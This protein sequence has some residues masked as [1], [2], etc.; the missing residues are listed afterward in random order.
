MTT[1]QDSS[2]YIAPAPDRHAL[3]RA[4]GLHSLE[5]EFSVFGLMERAGAATAERVLRLRRDNSLPVLLVAGPGNNGGDALVTARR[6][7]RQGVALC[8]VLAADPERQPADAAAALAALR[9]AGV[10]VATEIPAGRFSLVVD[11]LFGIGLSRPLTGRYA[12]GVRALQNAAAA[13]P[14]L[15]LDCPSGLDADT[16]FAAG[17]SV[18]ATHT[19]SFIAAKPGLYTGAGPD[20]AGSIEVD[21]LGIAERD[22]VRQ[23]SGWLLDDDDDLRAA[24]RPRAKNSHKGDFGSLGVLGGA[25]GMTGAALLCGRAA[26]KLGCG[27]V[28]AGLPERSLAVDPQQAELMLRDPAALAGAPLTA[29]VCGPGLGTGVRADALLTDIVGSPLPLVLDADA[30][31]LIATGGLAAQR[32]RTRHGTSV[33]TPHPGE[34]ARLLGCTT[35]DIARDRVGAACRIAAEYNA[36]VAL[37]GCGTVIADADGQWWINASGNPLLA[38]AGTGDVLAGFVGALLAQGNNAGVA[39]RAAVSLHG[40]AADAALADGIAIG[41]AAGELID[42][43]RRIA[44]RIIGQAS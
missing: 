11:G 42:A 36:W 7:H 1:P 3:L 31:T 18:R 41:L 20:H 33:L 26:L 39:L 34:A 4:P 9:D 8:I 27:R 24:F 22:I 17:P 6:L 16:G 29:L 32:L 15:A 35:R 40:Q 23:A 5:K 38:T 37:K 21:T 19:L 10:A 25:P 30:L 12:E 43:A 14:L 2:L 44:S 13:C 28:Y